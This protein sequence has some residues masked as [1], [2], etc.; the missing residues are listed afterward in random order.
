M[1]NFI[2]S[3]HGRL[4]GLS[5]LFGLVWPA[6]GAAQTHCDPKKVL[7][8]EGCIKCHAQADAVWKSTPH[9]RTYA[10]LY[11]LPEA[12]MI[13]QKMGAGSIKRGDVCV[14]CHYTQIEKEGGK[15]KAVSGISCESCHGAG[16]DWVP[17]HNDYGGLGATKADE[18]PEHAKA[19]LAE[20]TKLGMRNPHNLYLMAKSCLACHTVPN[21][22]LV[23][24]AG[25]TAGSLDFE[26]VSWSQG[27]LR[28][29]FLR[30]GGKSNAEADP[31][32]LRVM[33]VSGLI[34]DL[35]Y[36]TRAVALATRKDKY[37]LVVAK[38]AAAKALRIYEIQQ[39]LKNK[40]LEKILAEFVKADLKINN[41]EQLNRIADQIEIAGLE[42]A[43]SSDGQDLAAVDKFIPKKNQYK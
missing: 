14:Q 41:A 39:S 11:R 3:V 2:L 10:T 25:H 15:L 40:Q 24:V 42:F 32:R 26:M 37:G 4:I 38:R 17:V 29:N 34:A 27:S 36:S 7:T 35:E 21:E 13:A 6:V 28:H 30:T 5:L 31:K 16:K 12:K 1:R 20:A 23:N 9:Y 19:R 33:W 22:K 18:S 8:S 43:R